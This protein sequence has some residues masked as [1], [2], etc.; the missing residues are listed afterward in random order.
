MNYLELLQALE[1][2]IGYQHLPV[3]PRA[4]TLKRIFEGSP[5]HHE[6]MYRIVHALYYNN[7]CHLLTDAVDREACFEA[8]GPVRQEALRLPTT[9]V[10]A[11]RLLD[12]LCLAMD[13]IFATGH[14][15]PTNT[16]AEEKPPAEVIRLDAVRRHRPKP[17]P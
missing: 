8:I 16:V 9:D 1:Q 7:G 15:P 13:E 6:L 4:S 12:D 10:D 2:R 14:A 11:S 3:N 17:K 5:V